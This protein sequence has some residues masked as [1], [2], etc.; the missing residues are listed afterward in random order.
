[1]VVIFGKQNIKAIEKGFLVTG[2]HQCHGAYAL[3][4]D[5]VHRG[6]FGYFI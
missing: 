1:M 3:F 5:V 2:S 6:T 4:V